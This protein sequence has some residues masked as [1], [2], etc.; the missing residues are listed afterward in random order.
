VGLPD[1]NLR[2]T[3]KGVFKRRQLVNTYR[4]FIPITHSF[5]K[6]YSGFWVVNFF[7]TKYVQVQI[8]CNLSH[9]IRSGAYIRACFV[10]AFSELKQS[11]GKR[12]PK[13]LFLQTM[14]A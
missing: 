11:I 3:I 10:C 9:L 6:I 12:W 2:S 5:H 13:L 7:L 14:L 4:T 8:V 1:F